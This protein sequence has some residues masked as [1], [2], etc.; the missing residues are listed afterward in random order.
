MRIYINHEETTSLV[1]FYDDEA[2]KNLDRE[3]IIYGTLVIKYSIARI[4]LRQIFC[5]DK[6]ANLFHSSMS[7]CEISQAIL[8]GKK[9]L[10]DRRTMMLGLSPGNPYFYNLDVLRELL[11]FARQS[12]DKVGRCLLVLSWLADKRTFSSP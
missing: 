6:T 10:G 11:K 8:N 5:C 4:R 7:H 12:S 1:I 9:F 2:G 3:W